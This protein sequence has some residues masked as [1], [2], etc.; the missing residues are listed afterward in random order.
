MD[1]FF[2]WLG[3]TLGHLI[4]LI[5]D[6]LRAVLS[7]IGSALD[8]FFQGLADAVGMSPSIVNY[9]WLGMGILLLVAAVRAAMRKSI[10]AAIIWALLA[11]MV[12]GGLIS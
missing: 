2:S 9:L 10:L 1:G 7:S 6:A 11:T 5:I 8:S 12:L 3:S 4:T